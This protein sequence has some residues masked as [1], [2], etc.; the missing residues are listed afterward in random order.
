M[1][2]PIDKFIPGINILERNIIKY[3]MMPSYI[4]FKYIL[5]I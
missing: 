5:F 1:L 3:K 2:V 4:Y